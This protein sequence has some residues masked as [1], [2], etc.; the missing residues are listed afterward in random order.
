MIDKFELNPFELKAEIIKI[1]EKLK[2]IKDFENYEIHYK[3]LDQQPDK[4]IITK[5]L[6]KEINNPDSNQNF[7]KFGKV[8]S[9]CY[10][11]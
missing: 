9:L 4:S 1:L 2:G 5:L 7:I 8:V 11:S 3:T 10:I 6:F